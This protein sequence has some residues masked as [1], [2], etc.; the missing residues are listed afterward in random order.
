MR[1]QFQLCSHLCIKSLQ[2]VES[3]DT[4]FGAYTFRFCLNLARALYEKVGGRFLAIWI[5]WPPLS[6]NQATV[7][8]HDVQL[9]NTASTGTSP[10]LTRGDILD[11]C[12]S[13]NSPRSLSDLVSTSLQSQNVAGLARP[14]DTVE[15]AARP[16]QGKLKPLEVSTVSSRPKGNPLFDSSMAPDGKAQKADKQVRRLGMTSFAVRSPRAQEGW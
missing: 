9:S 13:P 7:Y 11:I 6:Q 15:K 8:F 12:A 10:R 16:D 3:V 4:A 2:S 14:T 1:V 5:P